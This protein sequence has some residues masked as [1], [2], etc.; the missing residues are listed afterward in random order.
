M[1]LLV[2]F[3]LSRVLGGRLETVHSLKSLNEKQITRSWV[4]I[5]SMKHGTVRFDER[6]MIPLQLSPS[7][8]Q[9]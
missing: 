5:G 8:N 7:E 9:A 3:R 1:L 6:V 2:L 4:L